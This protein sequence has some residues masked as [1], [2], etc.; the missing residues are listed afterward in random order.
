MLQLYAQ[1]LYTCF[2]WCSKYIHFLRVSKLFIYL[3]QAI[4]EIIFFRELQT[5]YKELTLLWL[6]AVICSWF[7]SKCNTIFSRSVQAISCK[8]LHF[9]K[10]ICK[11]FSCRKSKLIFNKLKFQVFASQ[12]K[13]SWKNISAL[14][15]KDIHLQCHFASFWLVL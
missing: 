10:K 4:S 8:N 7:T 5:P 14:W 13:K 12:L 6:Y 15:Y 1:H 11:K 3:W 2:C 9:V